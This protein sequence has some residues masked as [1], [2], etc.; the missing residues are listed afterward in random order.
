MTRSFRTGLLLLGVFSLVDVAGPLMT[1]G[2]NPPMSIALAGSV[3]GLASL[4]CLYLAWHGSSRAVLSLAALRLLS[5]L[6]AVPAFFVADVPGAVRG[7]AGVIVLLNL[8][9][10]ALVVGSRDAHVVQA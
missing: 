9:G 10:I 5:A 6:T 4:V 1:D 8:V 3:L 2:D 7:L